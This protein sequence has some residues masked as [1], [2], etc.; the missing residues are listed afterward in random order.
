VDPGHAA[1]LE[2]LGLGDR[3]IH[4]DA[5]L[6]LGAGRGALEVGAE[7]LGQLRTAQARLSKSASALD[8][9]GCFSG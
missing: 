4:A 5:E 3:V 1:L 7:F 8:A 6:G 9:S 2:V